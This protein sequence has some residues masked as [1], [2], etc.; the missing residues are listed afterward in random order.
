MWY[1][2]STLK[3]TAEFCRICQFI[4]AINYVFFI[5]TVWRCKLVRVQRGSQSKHEENK[6]IHSE[7]VL[8]RQH[9]NIKHNYKHIIIYISIYLAL[10]TY[11]QAYVPK[12]SPLHCWVGGLRVTVLVHPPF[13]T[14]YSTKVILV[15]SL[16]A[17]HT[18]PRY[19]AP[20]R[21]C[22]STPNNY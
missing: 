16:F 13:D 3:C 7:A 22:K 4:T 1:F 14:H 2:I 5:I 6:Q 12:C 20:P 9:C 15:R 8:K 17:L 18:L 19:L 10:Y 21:L 11:W